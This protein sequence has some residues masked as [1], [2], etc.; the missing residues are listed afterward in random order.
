[1]SVIPEVV[2]GEEDLNPHHI[3]HHQFLEA[4]PFAD[5]LHG[6]RGISEW[7]FEPERI[8]TVSMPVVMDDGYV[9]TFK[10]YRVLHNSSRGP[11][12]GG[13][14]FHPNVDADE[15]KAL[16]T[17]MTWKCAL[18][19]VPFG[20]AKGGVECDPA[21]LS[22]DEKRRITRRF[23]AALGDAIG[24]HSDIPAP[25]L[26]TNAQTMAWIYDTYD[27]MHPG[28]NN[29]PIVTGKP[30]DIGGIPGRSTATAQGVAF[31]TEHFLNIGGLPGVDGVAGRTIAIQGFGNAGRHGAFIFHDMGATI[32]GVSDSQGGVYNPDGLDLPAVENHK[33][34]T[35]TVVGAP[36]T[37]ALAPLEI[38]GKPCDILVPAALENQITGA[39]ADDVQARLVVEAANGPT[40]PAADRI[41]SDKG[42]PVIPDIL[43][44][45]GGVVVSYLEWVQ[46]L[47]NE[48]WTEE[49][50]NER[51]HK[52]MNRA[53]EE[54]VTRRAALLEA[55]PH[56][57]ER[58]QRV[59]PD[60]PPLRRPDFRMAATLIA[61]GKCRTAVTQRGVWP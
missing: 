29:L 13:I 38:L 26:Y 41:L 44:N 9:H 54:V 40:T 30:L 58:W 55:L 7:L 16:A 15:V 5:D 61:V 57:Q 23:V 19:D 32:V 3:A 12:K 10:G 35:G 11:G 8:V 43:A 6:W 17:W 1:M 33:R 28:R 36:H 60:D 2:A 31:C 52:K 42:I 18:L 51:L 22:E 34:E 14:R 48:Q 56:F 46:N 25:D 24:P 45:A 4:V 27:M 47:Q 20:G 49:A 21:R 53:T 50:V 37:E 39:N 59:R